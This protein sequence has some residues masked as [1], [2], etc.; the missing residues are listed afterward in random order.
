MRNQVQNL[1]LGN[2][3]VDAYDVAVVWILMIIIFL[4]R[5]VNL[6]FSE[7]EAVGQQKAMKM[8]ERVSFSFYRVCCCSKP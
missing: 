4:Q 3:C 1:V 6:F 5:Y 8:S 7:G 2:A